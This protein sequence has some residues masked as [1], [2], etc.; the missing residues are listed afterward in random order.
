MQEQEKAFPSLKILNSGET[1]AFDYILGLLS[2]FNG[3]RL[4]AVGTDKPGFDMTYGAPPGLPGATPHI[5]G[6]VKYDS[7]DIPLLDDY[8]FMLSGDI[9]MEASLGFDIFAA[10]RFW[11]L[12]EA[13]ADISQSLLDEHGRLPALNSLQYRLKILDKPLINR[14]VLV[15]SHWLEKHFDVVT[16]PYIPQGYK[17]AV[18]L[19]HD[20]DQISHLNISHRLKMLK[21]A[22]RGMRIEDTTRRL[23]GFNLQLFKKALGS[24]EDFWMFPHVMA[25]EKKLGLRSTWFFASRSNIDD[26]AEH[27]LD[28]AYTMDD[29]RFAELFR[30]LRS[31]DFEIGLHA[32]YNAVDSS[33]Q[34]EEKKR[35]ENL[36][37]CLITGVR[38]HFWH[39]GQPFWNT[40]QAHAAA[41]FEYDSSLGFND[42]AGLRLACALPFR[43][44]DTH[45]SAA[46][47]VLQIPSAMMDGNY[48]Y[49]DGMTAARAVSAVCSFVEELKRHR[50]AAALN[51]HNRTSYPGN[52][53]YAEWGKAY[54]EIIEM[55][56]GDP[57]IFVGSFRQ[58][59]DALPSDPCA[60]Q[61]DVP[62]P[63]VIVRS[64]A[65]L[66]GEL[67]RQWA[68]H[69]T[70]YAD[71]RVW[72]RRIFESPT[73]ETVGVTALADGKWAGGFLTIPMPLRGPQGQKLHGGKMEVMI[74]SSDFRGR[75]IA[76][77]DGN[78]DKVSVAVSRALI[79]V[80]MQAGFQVIFGIPTVPAFNAH[81]PAGHGVIVVKRR[82][83]ILT[84][85]HGFAFGGGEGHKQFV[86]RAIGETL[87]AG[88][89]VARLLN[90]AVGARFEIQ[91]VS[92]ISP[93]IEA[94]DDE[95]A[96]LLPSITLQRRADYLNW[97][98]GDDPSAVL[99]ELR[100]NTNL[101][102]VLIGRL[103][104]PGS[105]RAVLGD[106]LVKPEEIGP[107][108]ALVGRFSKLA[109]EGGAVAILYTSYGT[110]RLATQQR[111]LLSSCGFLQYAPAV[112]ENWIVD[113]GNGQNTADYLSDS[114]WSANG[115][116]LDI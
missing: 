20:V 111:L 27:A 33:M 19:S 116:F 94:L 61:K 89:T 46:L 42:R 70:R 38:H 7:T 64:N 48:F 96:A 31:E 82:P 81:K 113:A 18:I 93:D 52:A 23:A 34:A 39:V 28:V 79:G 54:L 114:D 24:E 45:N 32:S 100:H 1:R 68:R 50:G 57:E 78:T 10:M 107:A 51:W 72:Q 59:I 3:V 60:P 55:L 6:V 99:L 4:E 97:R 47:P 30:Q 106:L 2:T 75:S 16:R 95:I 87:W 98:F 84:L 85:D 76:W 36:A 66:Y 53:T 43:P 91:R 110:G 103:P 9:P 69:D 104:R 25:A 13:H 26:K 49:Q 56:A 77:E 86:K 15:F 115:L 35:L 112:G 58:F 40:L 11:L 105:N 73:G 22:A 92:H 21:S 65:H 71:D 83:M 88:Q 80:S 14:Y 41:G 109:R 90:R 63:G 12:D 101:I 62:A 8:E 29:P 108:M 74:T 5:P 102:G 44:Y 67:Q 37:G 17:A